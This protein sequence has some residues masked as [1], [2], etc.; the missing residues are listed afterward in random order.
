MQGW[1]QRK[2]TSRRR[3]DGA[4]LQLQ[5]VLLSG[6]DIGEGVHVAVMERQ[7]L[8]CDVG[9]TELHQRHVG[10][11][12]VGGETSLGLNTH[13]HTHMHNKTNEQGCRAY[14]ELSLCAPPSVM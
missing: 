14:T 8:G 5:D 13:K 2:W 6:K 3:L 9:G 4:H 12:F 1:V 11:V 7:V 10:V